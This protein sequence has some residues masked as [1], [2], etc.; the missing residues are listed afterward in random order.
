MSYN[1]LEFMRSGSPLPLSN[2]RAGFTAVCHEMNEPSLKLIPHQKLTMVSLN[3]P[4]FIS[5]F[6]TGQPFESNL[7]EI[8]IE[9]TWHI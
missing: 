8:A 3:C 9:P 2:R 6:I 5:G 4:R 7:H 1:A